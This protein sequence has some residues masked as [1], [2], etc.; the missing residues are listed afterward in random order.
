MDEM[1][2]LDEMNVRMLVCYLPVEVAP[3]FVLERAALRPAVLQNAAVPERQ[4]A[5]LA[6]RPL[7]Q[8]AGCTRGSRMFHVFP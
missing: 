2:T 5:F 3:Q 1:I 8:V 7:A 6:L 4:A